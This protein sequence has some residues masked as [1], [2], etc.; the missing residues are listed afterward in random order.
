VPSFTGA[1]IAV[2]RAVEALKGKFDG[3]AV[4]VPTITGSVS[5]ITFLAA[6]PTTVEE[7]NGIFEKAAQADRW[8]G[9][10]KVTREPIV[11]SDVI[12]EPYGAIV[13]LSMTAVVDENLC[14]VFSWYDNEAGYTETLVRHVLKAAATL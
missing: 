1:A 11:S 6:R 10:L 12:G 3:A 8:Q 14:T 2:T 4:R 7:I 5:A 13:D 9:I